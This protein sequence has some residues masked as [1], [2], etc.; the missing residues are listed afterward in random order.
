MCSKALVTPERVKRRYRLSIGKNRLAA[1]ERSRARGPR[2]A[3]K[4]AWEQLADLSQPLIMLYGTHD[5]ASAGKRALFL[6]EQ[7]P[8]LDIRIVPDAAHLL[9]WDA[10]GVFL[11]AL[12]EFLAD[13][14]PRETPVASR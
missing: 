13:V 14:Y 6:K 7:Q 10:P 3:G 9:M 4:P 11:T 8:N 1:A 5:R 12:R 2:P